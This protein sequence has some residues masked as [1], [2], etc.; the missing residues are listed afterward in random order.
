MWGLRHLE[1]INYVV[2]RLF[3]GFGLH[4]NGVMGSFL[5]SKFWEADF[6]VAGVRSP[7]PCLSTSLVW[8]CMLDQ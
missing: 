3:Y 1:L 8:S 2:L 4:I 6:L 5:F 7:P